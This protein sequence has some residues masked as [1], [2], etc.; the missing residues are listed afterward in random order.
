M[1]SFTDFRQVKNTLQKHFL[2]Q[3]MY[4]KKDNPSSY[5]PDKIDNL[6][7]CIFIH[8]YSLDEYLEIECK[9]KNREM[10]EKM[11]IAEL[12][13]KD[14]QCMKQM[15]ITKVDT[16]TMIG[17][18]MTNEKINLFSLH[19]LSL[20]YQLHIYIVCK[21][22]KTYIEYNN[23]A[24]N[25]CIIYKNTS[26]TKESNT[27]YSVDLQVEDKKKQD[28]EIIKNQFFKYEKYNAIVKTISN[29]K[30]H[31]L[32]SILT[33]LNLVHNLTKPSKQDIYDLIAII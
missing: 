18:I 15:K 14:L 24:S 3:T 29:Y 26:L 32:D 13:K 11:K 2:T 16:Q 9:Y 1:E 10:E 20:Y 17:D 21:E 28:I 4:D 5:F 33:K 8:K 30:K 31:E 7:W 23:L 27:K 19:A 6:F 22:N 12:I 25:I